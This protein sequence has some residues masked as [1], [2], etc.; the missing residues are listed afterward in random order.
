[1]NGEKILI[2]GG[3]WMTSD[4]LLRLTKTRYEALVRYAREA[5]LNM[6]RSE[7]FSVRETDMFY[8]LCDEY[9]VMVTQQIFGRTILDEDL[10]IQCAEDTMLRIRITRA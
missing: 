7:G 10:A 4:M 3:A 1:V 6:L 2:R 9:G 5:G 8:D